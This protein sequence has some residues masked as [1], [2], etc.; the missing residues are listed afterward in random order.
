MIC[1][2][3]MVSGLAGGAVVDAVRISGP[4]VVLEV[5]HGSGGWIGLTPFSASDIEKSSFVDVV[6]SHAKD[7]V[8]GKFFFAGSSEIKAIFKLFEEGFDGGW[9]VPGLV[10]ASFVAVELGLG[11]FSVLVPQVCEEAKARD[12]AISGDG[13][14]EGSDVD[15]R[16]CCQD[17]VAKGLVDSMVRL[18]E[19]FGGCVLTIGFG[20]LSSGWGGW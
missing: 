11:D 13:V 12:I 18:E 19:F 5:I 20:D 7:L 4:E 16:D 2:G 6:V 17:L 1:C 9:W 8:E 15:F 3:P 14:A 10:H